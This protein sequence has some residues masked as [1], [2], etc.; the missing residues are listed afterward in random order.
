[1]GKDKAL[2]IYQAL[3]RH[4]RTVAGSVEAHR[5]LFYSDFIDDRD[6]WPTVDFAK[7]LQQGNDLGQRM[8]KAFSLALERYDKAII[9]GSDCVELNPQILEEAF[10]QLDHFP[11][12]IGPAHDGGYYLLGMNGFNPELFENIAWSTEKV[13][14]QTIE[15]IEAMDE[16]YFLL[17]GLSDI[18]VAEDWEKHGWKLDS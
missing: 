8:E 5:F 3:L 11:F 13:L 4:T 10:R 18:D 15:K 2:E 1:M 14:A 17:P 12:V 6:D 16:K 9:I 7:H